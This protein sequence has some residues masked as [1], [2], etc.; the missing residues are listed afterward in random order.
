[1]ADR[2][3]RRMREDKAGNARFLNGGGAGDSLLQAWFVVDMK[4]GQKKAH[5][6]WARRRY[7]LPGESFEKLQFVTQG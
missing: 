2:N 4:S 7:L 1:M 6:R 5:Q 3:E